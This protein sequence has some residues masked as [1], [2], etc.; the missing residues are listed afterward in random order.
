[1]NFKKILLILGAV[2]LGLGC[3]GCST[4]E[5]EDRGFPLAV[6]IDK[7]QEGMILSFD[8]PNLSEVSDGK[9]P[10]GKPV[11]ISVEAGAYYEAQKAYENNTNKVLDYNHLKA[12]ILNVD[13]LS[14]NQK[15]RD[16]FSWLEGEEVVARNTCLFAAKEQAAEI[17]TLTE[18]TGGS[19]GKYLEQMV[20]TQ[21]DFKENK[22]MTIGKLMNQWHNQNELLL[23]PV[24]TNN[25]GIPSIT[26][27]AVLDAFSYKGNITVEEAMKAFLCQG[28]LESFTYLLQDGTVLEIG[29]ISTRRETEPAG[30]KIVVTV[31]ISGNA[32][33]KKSAS[34]GTDGQIQKQLNRQ[35]KESLT[36]TAAELKEA[37]GI[38]ISNSFYLLGSRNRSLYEQ[39]GQEYEGYREKLLV[40]FS[41]DINVVRE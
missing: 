21:G 36:R 24:L 7:S 15:V 26:E 41:V 40:Q 9:K 29:D 34:G 18:D 38:D 20:E 28:L 14:D 37:P 13:F 30:D 25:G 31:G 10:G 32:R 17:L 22:V 23:I 39:F 16:L 3:A 2:V 35:L 8:F 19:V 11:S 12:V 1:M 5:L 6:G 33:V 27:Y 4:R